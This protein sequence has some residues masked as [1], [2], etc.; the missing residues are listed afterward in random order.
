MTTL[1]KVEANRR[2][3]ELSTGPRTAEGKAVV[4]R[5]ATRHGIFTTVPVIPGESL[6]SWESHRAGIVESLS[7]VGLLE[8]NLA[9]RAA[10]LLW[11]LQRLARY[12]AKIVAVAMR[13][14]DVPSLPPAKD[15]FGSLT[16]PARQ[17]TRDEQLRE[18]RDELRT[19]RAELADSLKARDYLRSGAEAVEDGSVPF[20]VAES[21]MI[22]AC[23]RAEVAENLLSD[24]PEFETRAFLKKLGLPGSEPRNVDWT[25]DLIDR[26]L[27]LYA[28]YA[29][30][31][32]ERFAA[33]IA[34]ELDE[35]VEDV[36]RTV[37][38]LEGEAAAITNLL[39]DPNAR[40][41]AEVLLPAGGRDER[42]TKYERHLHNLL[43]STLHELERQQARRVGESVVPAVVAE[44]NVT[45]D[46][47]RD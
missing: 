27:A 40:Q 12:E 45:V 46:S 7:P 8:I 34:V 38:R 35:C 44:V 22:T 36:N 23:T 3:A 30:E 29:G 19:S 20:G 32:P 25:R 31:S 24:P 37:K 39:G 21:I 15:E 14:V 13:E 1:A 42:I 16:E 41:R 6:D 11:R 9:E 47:D 33:N 17:R 5:N 43:T 28:G 2:N 26:G 4:A 18:I 10:L